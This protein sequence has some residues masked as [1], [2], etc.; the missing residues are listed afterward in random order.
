MHWCA[1]LDGA[2]REQAGWR[3]DCPVCKSARRLSVQ[4]PGRY[5]KWNT[6][7]GCDRAEVRTRLAELLPG[8]VSAR[9][10]PR[11]AIDADELV[12]LAL[13]DIPPQSKCLGMLELAGYSTAKALDALGIGPTHKGRVI[14]GLRRVR[15]LPVSVSLRRSQYLP[16]SVT[17]GLPISV[18]H[19]RSAGSWRVLT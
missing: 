15:G 16:V 8:C 2:R 3:A 18:S 6:F 13:A 10:S 9:Y 1:K 5:P 11:H 7:C 19:P 14:A 12:K 17:R 4:A